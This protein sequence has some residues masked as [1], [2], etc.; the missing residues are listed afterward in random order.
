MKK[1]FFTYQFSFSTRDISRPLDH[2]NVINDSLISLNNYEGIVYQNIKV[3]NVISEL[4]FPDG[5]FQKKSIVLLC[6]GEP[7]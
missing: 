5:N 7:I 3:I 6:E 1:T 2:K 4:T